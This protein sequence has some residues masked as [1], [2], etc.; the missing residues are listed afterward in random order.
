MG[1]RKGVGPEVTVRALA[2]AGL[3]RLSGLAVVGDLETIKCAAELARVSL[4]ITRFDPDRFCGQDGAFLRRDAINVIDLGKRGD[5]GDPLRYIDCAVS[6]IQKK[7]ASAVVT[8]PV[9]KEAISRS[10]VRFVGHTEYI[11]GLTRTAKYAMMFVAGTLKVTLVTRHIPLK[12]VGK[13]VT[14]AKIKDAISLTHDF[15]RDRMNIKKPVI[16]VCALNPHAGEGGLIGTEEINVIIPA[17]K[18]AERALGNIKGPIPADSAF[19]L[20][21]KGR[22]DCLISMYHDQAMIPLKTIA[23][24]ECVNV[25][26]GLPFIRTSPAHGTAYDIA[27]KGIADPSSMKAAVRL[28]IELTR[29]GR[30]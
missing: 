21:A 15:L 14:K 3:R 11:A 2:D 4:P 22:V 17:I 24:E 10:G 12:D 28:A 20:L 6:L 7:M 19:G 18:S 8:A 29:R 25:T 5:S 1:D 30:F 26:L 16:G 23:R 9:N 13:A 27:W